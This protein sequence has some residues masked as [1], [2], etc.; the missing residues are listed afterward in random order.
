M[1]MQKHFN[2]W[3]IKY[4][5]A[6]NGN[7]VVE[8]AKQHTFDLILMDIQMPLVDG[9][10]ATKI[11]RS[12]LPG[13]K[14]SVPI[15][16]VTAHASDS[17]RIKCLEAGMNDYLSKPFRSEDL[18]K[19]I[20]GFFNIPKSLP[21]TRKETQAATEQQPVP[22]FNRFRVMDVDYLK[23][24]A[25]NEPQ[26]VQEMIS[27]FLQRTPEALRTIR[28]GIYAKDMKTVWQTAH[29]MKPTFSYMGMKDTSVL[30]ADLEKLCKNAPDEVKAEFLLGNIEYDFSVAQSLIQKNFS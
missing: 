20:S 29:R 9:Y 6:T 26:F 2:D 24:V 7:E 27:I 8:L 15:I 17:E 21:A 30:A 5:V 19:K 11:I 14:A 13:E 3:K 18:L 12:T 4:R 10:G 16:A 25:M 28:E 23:R 22:A 1:I